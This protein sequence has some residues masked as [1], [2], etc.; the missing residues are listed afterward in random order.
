MRKGKTKI[1]ALLLTVGM[2]FGMS[3][4]VN[5]A[6]SYEVKSTPGTDT[7]TT[8]AV[9]RTKS[10]AEATMSLVRFADGR[11]ANGAYKSSKF[12]GYGAFYVT[13]KTITWRVVNKSYNMKLHV[14]YHVG[15]EG[16]TMLL[17]G[18]E[19]FENFY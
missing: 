16:D 1:L 15:A 5:A 9:T 4:S 8:V 17:E 2:V 6:G 7:G 10:K 12:Y 14:Y 3:T 11:I 18:D 13:G 19:L